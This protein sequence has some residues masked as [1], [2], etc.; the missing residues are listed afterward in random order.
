MEN[1][2]VD[3][4]NPDLQDVKKQVENW[5]RQETTRVCSDIKDEEEISDYRKGYLGALAR[6]LDFLRNDLR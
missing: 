2:Q 6:L 1:R 3:K 4:W 5:A